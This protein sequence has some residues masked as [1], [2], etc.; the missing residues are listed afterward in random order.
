MQNRN[1]STG[2]RRI[3]S[4][5][6]IPVMIV[7]CQN[8]QEI[9]KISPCKDHE[10]AP[11]KAVSD[12]SITAWFQPCCGRWRREFSDA[13]GPSLRKGFLREVKGMIL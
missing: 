6:L 3:R 1:V 5:P 7:W 13:L 2:I 8:E 12:L 4:S 9:R 10:A 11:Y